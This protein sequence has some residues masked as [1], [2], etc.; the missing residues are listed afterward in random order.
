MKIKMAPFDYINYFILGIFCFLTLYPFWYILIISFSTTKVYY[1]DWLHIIPKSFS[2]DAYKYNFQNNQVFLS[3]LTSVVVT[4]S[5]TIISILLTSMTAHFLAKKDIKGRNFIFILFIISMFI[6][7]GLI[8]SYVLITKLGMRNTIFALFIPLSINNYFLI[9]TKNYFSKMS[10]SLEE[11]ARLDGAN[12][13][14][15]LFRIII[16]VAKPM[17]AT[18]ALYYAVQF[19]NDW[20]SP[21]L[22]LSN[23]KMYPLSLYLRG[24]ISAATS[25][26]DTGDYTSG[27][28]ATIRAAV[29]IITITPIICVYPF[30]Q[31]HFVK[32]I[33]L[34]A[35][36]E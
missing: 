22:Y 35:V 27:S 13:L 24:L 3:F 28:P 9:L 15:I 26:I 30:L 21:M 14:I 5:G 19:W 2:L 8:P 11:S 4:V 12:E 31:K 29:I 34:G 6:H 16:P 1:S 32:G 33:M 17:I 20:F 10:P 18:I 23:Q 25:S 7:G 36:K